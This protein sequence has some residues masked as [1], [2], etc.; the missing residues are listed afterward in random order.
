MLRHGSWVVGDLKRYQV[1]LAYGLAPEPSGPSAGGP[2]TRVGGYN[3]SLSQ[4]ALHADQGWAFL[5]WF[6]QATQAVRF[7]EP[8][9]NLPARKS[10]LTTEESR[11]NP[12]IRLF[13]E[14][15]RYAKPFPTA[16]WTQV[17]WDTV[18]VEAT[19]AILQR[20]VPA[21]HALDEAARIVQAEIAQRSPSTSLS[22]RPRRST[23]EN[24]WACMN[25]SACGL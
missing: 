13:F 19:N 11:R 23:G 22:R 10:A 24:V 15:L 12:E 20:K 6:T 18:N 2:A 14:A 7:A 17:M 8:Q 21:R 25:E 16:P 1:Q 3:W 4:G 5:S 9:G